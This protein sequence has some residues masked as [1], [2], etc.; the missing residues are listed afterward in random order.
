MNNPNDD[1]PAAKRG[2]FITLTPEQFEK[3]LDTCSAQ[4]AIIEQL[5]TSSPT[6]VIPGSGQQMVPPLYY[7]NAKYKEICLQAHQALL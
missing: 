7:S 5:M 1:E 4:Q 6:F 2:K 3:I